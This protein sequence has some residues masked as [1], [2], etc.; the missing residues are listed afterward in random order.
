MPVPKQ[1]GCHPWDHRRCVPK[2]T[3]TRASEEG[4]HWID[5]QVES[6]LT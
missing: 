4:L 6:M 1:D 3:G 5:I 2:G